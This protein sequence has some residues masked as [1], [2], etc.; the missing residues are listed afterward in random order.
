MKSFTTRRI[1]FGSKEYQEELKLRE[2]ILRR[3]IGLDLFDEDLTKE[4]SDIHIGAF[5][6]DKLIGVLILTKT[7]KESIRMRQVAVDESCRGLGVGK[8][9]VEF[10]ELEAKAEGYKRIHLHARKT[11]VEFYL[12]LG[13]KVLGDEFTEV[14]IPHLEMDK[15]LEQK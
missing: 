9:M 7:D 1:E 13:Y 6:E 12:K 3:P 15:L 5:I 10:C 8:M 4:M 14:G 11:A 2:R